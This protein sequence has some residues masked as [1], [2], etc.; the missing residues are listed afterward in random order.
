[1]N[2]LSSLHNF[3]KLKRRKLDAALH[4]A[5]LAEQLRK[6]QAILYQI[7]QASYLRKS[8]TVVNILIRW[9]RNFLLSDVVPLALL[10]NVA[11]AVPA[12]PTLFM[13]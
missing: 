1:M 13:M 11:R 5:T 8:K 7:G 3:K 10:S 2:D 12:D 6:R 4:L 9:R